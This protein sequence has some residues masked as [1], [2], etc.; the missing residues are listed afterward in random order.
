MEKTV[1]LVFQGELLPGR[2]LDEVKAGLPVLMKVPPEQVEKLFAGGSVVIKRGLPVSKLAAYQALLERAGIC[3]VVEEETPE[4]T[5]ELEPTATPEAASADS[6]TAEPQIPA[7]EKMTCPQC[8]A[9]QPKRTLCR[10]CGVDMPRYAAAQAT[11]KSEA[12]QPAPL[13]QNTYAASTTWGQ[14][15]ELPPVLGLSFDGRLNRMRYLIY[16]LGSYVV[17]AL[18][19]LMTL[20]SVFD[21]VNEGGFP[22]LS[23]LLLGGVFL[24]LVYFG[25]RFSVQRLHDM[26]MT[27]WLVLL[28]FAPFVGWLV[29]VWLSVWP[30]TKDANQYG[31]P[32]PP[33]SLA[34]KAI[35][36]GLVLLLVLLMGVMFSKLVGGFSA[37][38]MHYEQHIQTMPRQ[39]SDDRA[40]RQQL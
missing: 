1:R 13:A 40:P 28:S 27:G 31:P 20:G 21:T 9:R 22:L 19:G 32:N 12:I 34:H 14:E 35:V 16:T 39:D 11:L 8:G 25:L 24:M 26:G 17:L 15:D 18:A 23:M 3:V 33:N 36:L 10:S 2:A 38:I 30:G 29:W 37:G 4:F 6:A 7:I 5:L